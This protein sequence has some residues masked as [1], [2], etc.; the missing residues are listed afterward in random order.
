VENKPEEPI[1]EEIKQMEVDG[2]IFD[3]DVN[4]YFI[5]SQTFNF[6][7]TKFIIFYS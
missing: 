3:K 1:V 2:E 5:L 6:Q 7:N 4:I